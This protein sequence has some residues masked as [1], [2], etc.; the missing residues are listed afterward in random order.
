MHTE[1]ALAS[2]PEAGGLQKDSRRSLAMLSTADNLSNWVAL[3][4]H[5]KKVMTRDEGLFR[6]EQRH[7]LKTDA[8]EQNHLLRL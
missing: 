7:Q 6:P 1:T 3:R 4:K 8:D 2:S 5:R